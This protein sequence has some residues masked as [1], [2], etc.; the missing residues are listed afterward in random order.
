[1]RSRLVAGGVLAVVAALLVAWGG[2]LDLPPVAVLGVAVGGCL[3]SAREMTLLHRVGGFAGGALIAWLGYFLRAG[4]LPDTDNGRAVAAF[5]VVG[6][7]AVLTLA[8]TP[9]WAPL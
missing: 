5:L 4:F 9:F 6:L 1:M 2:D 8:P 7:C 3:A